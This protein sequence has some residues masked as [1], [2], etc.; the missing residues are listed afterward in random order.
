[1]SSNVE[2][3]PITI[4][5]QPFGEHHPYEHLPWERIP[6]E[7]NSGEPVILGIETRK[8]AKV[9]S[10][11]CVWNV[12]GE[13]IKHSTE[14]H[15]LPSAES[16]D[17]WEV[18]LPAFSGGQIVRYRLFARNGSKQA[19]SE[20]YTFSV[21]TWVKVKSLVAMEQQANQLAV[22]VATET[23]DLQIRMTFET[24][25]KGVVSLRLTPVKKDGLEKYRAKPVRQVCV[26]LDGIEI[27]LGGSPLRMELRR[28][29]D[30]MELHSLEPVRFLVKNNGTV[31]TFAL[32]FNSPS[33]E[34]FYGFGER[35]NAFDQRGNH[36]DNHVYAQYTG[37]GKRSYIP[38]PFF[39]SSR[40]YGFWLNTKCQAEFDLACQKKDR[41]E[42]VGH[43]EE[44]C[45]TFEMKL[46]FQNHPKAIVE[47][48]T[49]LTGKPKLPPSWAFGLWM[50]SNDWNTQSE[51]IRQLN[52]SKQFQIPASVMVIEAW[53][54]E[55]NFYIWNDATYKWKPSS[56]A[57]SLQ[58][59]RFP[60]SGRWPDPKRMI[61]DIH[62]AGLRVVL[63]QI[64]VIK[65]GN[66]IEKLD[67]AQKVADEE[68]AI[69]KGLIV[70]SADGSPYFIEEH[71]PWFPGS[72][73][74]DFT[75]PEA[76][77]WWF[78]KRQYLLTE[79]GVD[80]F[81][82]DGGEHIWNSDTIF[83]NGT[84]GK[85]GINN[86]PLSYLSAYHHF[87]H[88]QRGENSILFSRA[89]YTGVQQFSCHWTGDEESTWE[90]FRASLRAMLNAGLC[91]ISFIGWDMAGFAGDI[92]SGELYLRTVAFS[93]FCPIMQF[94]SDTNSQRKP[95]QDRTPWNIQE[96]TG[97]LEVI[98]VFRRFVNLRMNLIP[99]I[100]GQ[101]S[102]SS[103]TGIPL[104]RSLPME[105]PAD[106]QCREFPYEYLFGDALLVAPVVE[107]GRS[108]MRI[109][110]PEGEW[111]DFWS[112]KVFRGSRIIEVSTPKDQIP[113]FQREG[114]LVPLN[115]GDDFEFFSRVG[116]STEEILNLAVL[117][118]PG[119]ISRSEVYQG[120]SH[121]ALS[122]NVHN[123][124]RNG[125]VQI[126]LEGMRI[127]VDLW[128]LGNKPGQVKM[129]NTPVP[130]SLSD[131]DLSSAFWTWIPGQ[132]LTRIH[133]P[134]R[135]GTTSITLQH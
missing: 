85:Q 70:R 43:I 33:D 111:S 51:I 88:E 53:S 103:R 108:S 62:E 130:E 39:I 16:V 102:E 112:G 114:S 124:Y 23:P 47:A 10:V 11:W 81:K 90:A 28:L 110:L 119:E 117:I 50:S 37:Q 125:I 61:E 86:Y 38:V 135:R 3:E 15:K 78:D 29:K 24:D 69:R 115:L 82:T 55:I 67:E 132:H 2:R 104:M 80:G 99:Y 6:R 129:G 76:A 31:S 64:P 58:D 46:F 17:L 123:E 128:V 97:E 44:E 56:Q 34:A 36:L 127:P 27:S 121:P 101:A 106:P 116:N 41:W 72:L 107:E 21:S 8:S 113:V 30:G 77:K 98:P 95:C 71:A 49:E 118:F 60:K 40:G 26:D 59:Y 13:S 134:V 1:M 25:H 83:H 35:F 120:K 75:N 93:V 54:D 63:W 20:E 94:H 105:F 42:I 109:Y 65:K 4:L 32:V 87:L 73:V 14:S 5:H 84:S 52:T 91:G 74:L 22:K 19:V 45:S 131:N 66:P 126:V 9:D 122:I 48:F 96:R 7:P 100:L 12:L 57:Y 89:G 68:Y 18:K 133:F 79:M 92:P